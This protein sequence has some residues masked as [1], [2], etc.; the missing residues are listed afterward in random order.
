MSLIKISQYTKD[1]L[2]KDLKTKLA[3]LSVQASCTDNAKH[4]PEH[5]FT[6]SRQETLIGCATL[7]IKDRVA[8]LHNI[9]I[10]KQCQGKR[11]GNRLMLHLIAKSVKLGAESIQ[12][13]CEPGHQHFFQNAGFFSYSESDIPKQQEQA[14]CA[15]ENPCPALYLATYRQVQADGKRRRAKT[16][17]PLILAHDTAIHNYHTER[18][19]LALHRSM[20]GQ[21]R[22]KIW[23][24]CET[25]TSSVLDNEYTRQALFRLVR[26]NQHADIKILLANDKT[27]AGHY[28]Q[29]LDLAQ[30]L[31]SYIEIRTL[32]NSGIKINEALTLID[33]SACIFRKNMSDF[34][35]FA[36]Y[37]SRLLA[38]RLEHNF[39]HQW[40]FA[41]PSLELRRLAI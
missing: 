20:F 26:Y 4:A 33:Y 13:R 8:T 35:G 27:G 16:V 18:Q 24:L 40:Q 1:T 36:S 25:I 19:Y 38:Q 34:S 10:S 9:T 31:S 21:A 15:M 3:T 29:T 30:R 39:E 28:S 2:S 5:Y 22:K 7:S 37:N 41:K 14:S 12:L 23:I 6:V 11:I 17:S 32:K